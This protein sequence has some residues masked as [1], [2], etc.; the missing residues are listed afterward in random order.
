MT[1]VLLAL[2]AFLPSVALLYFFYSADH[3]EPEPRGHV[4]AAV[5]LGALATV[6]AGLLVPLL[7][8]AVGPDFLALGGLPGRAVEAFALEGL[9][10][11]ALKW[12]V[13]WLV[14]Y[15]WRE[16][17][18]PLDGV[19][20]GVAV[21][22]GF[23]TLENVVYV[24][25]GGL[26]VGLLRAVFAVPEHALLGATMGSFLGAAKLGGA[27]RGGR[28]RWVLAALLLP[29]TLHGAYNLLLLELVG[30]VMYLAVG[31]GVLALWVGVLRRVAGDRERSPFKPR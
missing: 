15:R 23:G 22:L 2:V 17:D 30:P 9:P 13:M 25:R 11:E 28:A 6:A 18:E 5:A 7:A 3:Y 21:A 31:A 29:A 19:I 20:Y 4:V 10:E 27:G 16:F 14:I 8:A 24:A 1:G 12:A 26:A